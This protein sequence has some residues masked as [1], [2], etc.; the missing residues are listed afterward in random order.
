[1]KRSEVLD[2]APWTLWICSECGGGA[3]VADNPDEGCHALCRT[4]GSDREPYAVEVFPASEDEKRA[5][6][7]LY[8]GRKR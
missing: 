2:K 1:M 6:E 3:E 4:C 5:S 8:P 7:R